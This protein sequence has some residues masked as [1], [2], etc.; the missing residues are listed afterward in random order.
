M[1]LII[2]MKKFLIN[3]IFIICFCYPVKAIE[4]KGQFY[5][6][7][8][9]IGRTMP[10]SKVYIDNK[11]TKVSEEGYFVIGLSKDRFNDVSIKVVNKDKSERIIKKIYKKKYQIQKIDGLPK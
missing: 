3:L 9:V 7:N 6:G 11:R 8:L 10:G 2:L 5:Q 1:Y 4:F